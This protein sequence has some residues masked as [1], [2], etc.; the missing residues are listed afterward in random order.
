MGVLPAHSMVLLGLSPTAVPEE[1]HKKFTLFEKAVPAARYL[2]T[3]VTLIGDV[4]TDE[5]ARA[6]SKVARMALSRTN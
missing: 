4:V 1:E 6:N 5:M 3:D 2:L